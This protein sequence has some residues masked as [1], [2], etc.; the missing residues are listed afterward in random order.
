MQLK[1]NNFDLKGF[2]A[3]MIESPDKMYPKLYS[4]LERK[5]V[6]RLH[7][8]V[9]LGGVSKIFEFLTRYYGT[10]E[11][12][13]IIKWLEILNHEHFP[14]DTSLIGEL[15]LGN[16]INKQIKQKWKTLA[17]LTA[18]T[19]S[20]EQKWYQYAKQEKE[21]KSK[22]ICSKKVIFPD[23]RDQ[24]EKAIKFKRNDKVCQLLPRHHR[25]DIINGLNGEHA[26]QSILR[27][28]NRTNTVLDAAAHSQNGFGAEDY[29][30]HLQNGHENGNEYTL[31][32]V[33]IEDHDVEMSNNSNTEE[34][35]DDID[36]MSDEVPWHSPIGLSLSLLSRSMSDWM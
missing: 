20:I 14:I 16:F 6:F 23:A 25:K 1:P 33:E 3:S 36:F 35:E 18:L 17:P 27:V 34:E 2:F 19:N 8:F 31:E 21:E 9:E 7:A 10:N 12:H 29:H 24:Y 11:E 4:L 28:S 13:Q 15:G 26:V 22:R 32:Y 30:D 5:D